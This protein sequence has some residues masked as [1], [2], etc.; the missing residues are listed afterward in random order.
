MVFNQV[1]DQ[2]PSSEDGVSAFADLEFWH[3]NSVRALQLCESGLKHHP[4]SIELLIKKSRILIDLERYIEANL[5][6]QEVISLDF[7]NTEAR[8]LAARIRENVAKNKAGI[9]YDFIYFDKQFNDPWHLVSARYGRQTRM[10]SI[11]ANINY[12]SRFKS[13]GVQFEVDAYPRI[14]NR[15]YTYVSGAYSPDQGVFPS[16]RAGFSLYANLPQSFEADAGFRYLNFGDGTWTY[17]GS[18]GKYIRNYWLNVRGYVTPGNKNLSQS[19]TLTGRY[20]FG[21][22]ED[23]LTLALGSGISPDDRSNIL[24]LKGNSTLQSQ[25]ITAGY[26][27]AFHTFYVLAI[28]AGIT[29]Q[30]Y[31]KDKTGTQLETSIGFH[32]RF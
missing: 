11:A 22:P 6:L 15:F 20:Y 1:I 19:Y 16:Y 5:A 7:K 28:N 10:G 26:R 27:N 12:A 31:L 2:D 4:A 23:Y 24:Q 14:S 13:S 18:V 9:Q 8:A 3:G 17:T 29:R 30:E 21:G 25:K 32:V